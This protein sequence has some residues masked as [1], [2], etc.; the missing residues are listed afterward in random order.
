MRKKPKSPSTVTTAQT[1]KEKRVGLYIGIALCIAFFV[2]VNMVIIFAFSAEDREESGTRSESVTAFVIRIIYPDFDHMSC[3][4]QLTIK[5]STHHFVRKTA[6]F[7]EYALLGLLTSCL[8]LFIRRYLFRRKFERWKTWLYPAVFC[9]LYAVTDE[10][11]QI[12]SNRGA[13]AKD[14]LIDAVGVICG[15]LFIQLIVMSVDRPHCRRKNGKRNKKGK[16][17]LPNESDRAENTENSD[18]LC[19]SEQEEPPCVP[20]DTV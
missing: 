7:L 6:H 11:H 16:T 4:D 2:V 5:D 14:V 19:E 10:V 18:A 15:I 3:D 1:C 13:S 17:K 12:F 9:V 8:L 20:P